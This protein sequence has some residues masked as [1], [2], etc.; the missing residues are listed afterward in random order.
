ML[1]G[2]RSTH[3]VLL[4]SVESKAFRL[5]NS[6]PLTD[7]LQPLSHRRNV[8]SL[9]IFYR[10]FHANCS[11]DLAKC[12]PPL[13]LRPRCSRLSFSFRPCSVQL[14]NTRVNQYSQSFIPFTGKLW[15]SLPASVF[16]S[17]YD[18]TF[19]KRD[20]DICSLILANS[21]L[22]S[23]REPALKCAFFYF[24]FCVALG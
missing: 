20:Q 18:L 21:L 24:L 19:F 3:T 10:Y 1:G 8:A 14:T 17:S 4:D 15:N 2:G 22:L 9:C 23:F 16:P 6:T 7:C 13:F 5:I 11:T 12:M